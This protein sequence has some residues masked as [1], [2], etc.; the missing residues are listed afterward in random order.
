MTA[1]AG[2]ALTAVLDQ[3]K[4]AGL[5]RDG[6]AMRDQ[7][8]ADKKS[9][10]TQW[11][12]HRSGNVNPALF[13]QAL[14][15]NL[16][17]DG[18]TVVDDG[19]HTFLTA[20]LFTNTRSRHFI[21]PTDFNCMGYCVPAVIGAKLANPDKQVVGIVGDG[22]FLMT[23][24]E[25]L[26]AATE[27]LNVAYFVFYDGEL[28]QIAQGQ[29]IPYNRKTCT[30]LGKIGLQGVADAVGARYL[31]MENDEHIESVIAEALRPTTPHGPVIV[32]VKI[33]YSK[34]TRFTQGVV[35]AV[36]SRLPLGEKMRFVGRAL[37]RKVTG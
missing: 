32:D 13:F 12:N 4:T 23:C 16:P 31:C 22:A 14:R 17:D 28:A 26:T 1:D 21:C 24:M 9:Y 2:A 7:I 35:K 8:A 30:I 34:P 18:I 10:I 5:S 19:N 11:Q 37:L 33:D 15:S 29:Q 27:N 6:S 25:I 3:L 20:E 36:S